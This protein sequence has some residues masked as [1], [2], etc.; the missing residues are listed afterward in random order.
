MC[1]SFVGQAVSVYDLYDFTTRGTLQT[2]KKWTQ[3]SPKL[4]NPR[5]LSADESGEVTAYANRPVVQSI[6]QKN[7]LSTNQSNIIYLCI[8]GKKEQEGD[9]K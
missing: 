9:V 3:K 7:S 1:N 2:Y 4:R 5:T 6:N 8:Y